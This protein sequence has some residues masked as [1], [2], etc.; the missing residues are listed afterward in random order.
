MTRSSDLSPVQRSN[1]LIVALD[2]VVEERDGFI[3]VRS[4]RNP[5][6]W[7]GNS[8]H[9]PAPPRSF[10]E[11]DEAWSEAFPPEVRHRCFAWSG[12]E[13]SAEVA[14]AA[15]AS[16]YHGE[17]SVEFEAT[18][19]REPSGGWAVRPLRPTGDD[20]AFVAL[21]RECDGSEVD[22]TDEYARFKER[23]RASFL[24][25]MRDG[26]AQWFAAFD[27]DRPVGQC[28]MVIQGD[29]GRFQAVE[30]HPEYRRRGVASAVVHAAAHHAFT[31]HGCARV[32][33]EA[34]PDGPA[35]GM[36]TALGFREIGRIHALVR[37]GDP[38]R[39]RPEVPADH[40]GVRSLV[41]AAFDSDEEPALVESLRELPGTISLVAER[42]GTLLGH[43]LLSEATI[44]GVSAKGL[45]LAPLAVSPRYQRAGIGKQLTHA[46]LERARA[47]GFGWCVVLGHPEYYPQFGFVPATTFGLHCR[48]PVP[49]DT[50]M[51]LELEPGALD[52]A[53]GLVEYAFGPEA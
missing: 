32:L 13:A 22:A 12:G 27:G 43:V 39:V 10:A 40:A 19:V 5:G 23:I 47:A 36:Y 52:G 48:W 17:S 2:G 18:D 7:H 38:A 44:A 46:A 16:G 53:K 34:E 24:G 37:A 9:L 25:W 11:L 51:A 45:G 41:R 49:D 14:R 3:V 21:N 6:W 28:G 20:A 42:G 33:L 15:A 30:T 29:V 26:T 8:L 4:P 31:Q 50:F 35:L 1:A